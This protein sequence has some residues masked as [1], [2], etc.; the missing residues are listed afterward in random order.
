MP[1]AEPPPRESRFG[2]PLKLSRSLSDEEFLHLTRTSDGFHRDT[3]AS[4][5]RLAGRQ[6]RQR[7]TR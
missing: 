5:A 3:L 6:A 7:L 1:L 4:A 2:S